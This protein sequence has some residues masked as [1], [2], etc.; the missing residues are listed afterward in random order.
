MIK[1]KKTE[2]IH[3]PV[4]MKI[5]IS[6][7]EIWMNKNEMWWVWKKRNGLYLISDNGHFKNCVNE[8]L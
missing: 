4:K 5:W 1:K 2:Y 6:K 8:Y 3:L 7:C